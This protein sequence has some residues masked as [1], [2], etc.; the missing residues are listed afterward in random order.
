MLPEN[1]RPRRSHAAFVL[2]LRANGYGIVRALGRRNVDVVGV[3]KDGE[4]A[5]RFS[6]YC[7][8]Y[9]LA[10]DK[11]TDKGIC[12]ALIAWRAAFDTKPVLF[13][14][15]DKYAALL[16]RYHDILSEHFL[17]HWVSWS[18]LETVV[19][20]SKICRV[21]QDEGVV[22]PRTHF[23]TRGD[24][25]AEIARDFRFPC[26]IKP[27]RS[28][29]LEGG[30]KLRTLIAASPEALV[31]FFR[32]YPGLWDTSIIQEVIEGED[33]QV[34]Q[35]NFVVADDGSVAASCT[36]R[37]LQQFKPGFGHMALGRTEENPE[38]VARSLRLL[39]ALG[40]RGLAS[41]EFKRDRQSGEYYF[42][43]MNPR[44]PWYG[45]LFAD[46]GVNLAHAA[47][48]D[49]TGDLETSERA[50][51]QQNG[52]HWMRFEHCVRWL[53]IR[54]RQGRASFWPWLK[55]V[56]RARSFAWW[57]WRDPLPCLVE[58]AYRY[59]YYCGKL[60]DLV[61]VRKSPA[62]PLSQTAPV[63]DAVSGKP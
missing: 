24:N 58:M 39:R 61:R 34:H 17:F 28:F 38:L 26:I 22:A 47:Y 1:P 19:D 9:R 27:I 29:D 57:D 49:L 52:L 40:W 54:G 44:M 45:G 14:S 63:R 23:A 48:A 30:P 60:I 20:K 31:D 21:C 59:A 7:R 15:S 16:A 8:A 36:V 50:A 56:S 51:R 32:E 46:A 35:C 2:G 10:P 62:G 33:D 13:V 6:R 42:I 5:G 12:E 43:E 25:L 55:V 37:K 3:Y 4:E 41:L 18:E 11:Q 53:L